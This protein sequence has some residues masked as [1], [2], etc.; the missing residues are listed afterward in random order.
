M[1]IKHVVLDM[2]NIVTQKNSEFVPAAIKML[3]T[4]SDFPWEECAYAIAESTNYFRS[5]DAEG[6]FV[7]N[8]IDFAADVLDRLGATHVPT[9]VLANR[10][11]ELYWDYPAFITHE[12][13]DAIAYLW[14]LNIATH[15]AGNTNMVSGSALINH[16]LPVFEDVGA[17]IVSDQVGVSMPHD[18]FW[19]AVADIAKAIN[20]STAY[21]EILF[22][23][24]NAKY[25]IAATRAG[26]TVAVISGPEELDAAIRRRVEYIPSREN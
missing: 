5:L 2:Y 24:T 12:S 1:T 11:D 17:I 15:A 26:L 7:S 16:L 23:T 14:G 10:F 9:L 6:A 19:L 22:V 21:N 18:A 3:E 4:L 20:P 13:V 8:P 25:G